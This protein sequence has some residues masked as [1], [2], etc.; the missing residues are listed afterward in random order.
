MHDPDAEKA[1][2]QDR[3]E[4]VGAGKQNEI[5]HREVHVH[6]AFHVTG[7]VQHARQHVAD[8]IDDNHEAEDAARQARH[9]DGLDFMDE[10]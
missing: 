6:H 1:E 3:P 2:S 9:L 5:L 4:Q 7:T 10:G 8:G